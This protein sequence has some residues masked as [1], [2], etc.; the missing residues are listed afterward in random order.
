MALLL[1]IPALTKPRRFSA[2]Y[3]QRTLPRRF[4]PTATV[5]VFAVLT[6]ASMKVSQIAAHRCTSQ[7]TRA[8]DDR[9]LR[10]YHRR[11]LVERVFAWLHN[12]QR[13]VARW[14]YHAENLLG[15][16]KVGC[17]KSLLRSL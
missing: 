4:G 9:I 16:V 2:W 11:R 8:Q 3:S 6:V 7:A 14:E 1:G 10:R 13:L 15:A 5:A 12:F 17:L